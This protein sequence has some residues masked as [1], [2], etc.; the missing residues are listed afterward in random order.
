MP[1]KVGKQAYRLLIGQTTPRRIIFQLENGINDIHPN[2]LD[3][4]I[5]S[6]CCKYQLVLEQVAHDNVLSKLTVSS[7]LSLSPPSSPSYSKDGS[8]T[9]GTRCDSKC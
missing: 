2:H 3:F 1:N 5:L 6:T 8:Y 7:S 9:P 4:T